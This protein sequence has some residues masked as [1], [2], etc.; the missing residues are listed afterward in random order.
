M[1]T[2]REPRAFV[3]TES[4]RCFDPAI[5]CS[6]AERLR[7]FVTLICLAVLIFLFLMPLFNAPFERDQGTYATIARGWIRGALPYKDLW[8]NKGPLLYL[9]YIA[10]F[11]LFGEN[12]EA[13]RIAA[14]IAAGLSLFFVWAAA[15]NLFGRR[16]AVIA[17]ILFALFFSDVFLQVTA[18]G[19]VFMLLPL[20]ASFWAFVRGTKK[21]GGLWFLLSGILASLAVFTRQSAIWTLAGYGTWL[22]AMYLQGGEQRQQQILALAALLSGAVLGALPFIIYFAVHGALYD[23]WYAMF[24]FN[25]GWVAAQSFLLKLVPPLFVEPGPLIGGLI[26]WIMAAVGVWKL[27][28]RN[29][30]AAWLVI[31]FLA[32]SEAAAQT[33]GKG[34]AHYS[35]QLVPGA[36]IAAAFG[37]RPILECWKKGGRLV[38]TGLVIAG[39]MTMSTLLFAYSRPTPESR[40]IVQYT[41]RDYAED[42]IG[43][44]AIAKAVAARSAPGA[45]VYEWGR[46]SQIYFLADRQPC[47]RWFYDRPYEVDKSMLPQVM[48]D[49]RKK[50]PAVILVTAENPPPP[51]LA[52]LMRE[53]YC[54]AGK[55]NYAKLYTRQPLTLHPVL[56]PLF[57]RVKWTGFSQQLLMN[58]ME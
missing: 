58:R 45:C 2:G 8:D 7:T 5:Y 17:A 47:S 13:P 12:I 14:A 55:V 33:M 43:A 31:S 48:T 49:L 46:S 57:G 54:Y 30:R 41:F 23:L 21:K 6:K 24:G 11:A 10:S 3:G 32:A 20:A 29:D 56:P 37:F 19:E 22:A 36:A 15:K 26:F 44:P 39:S 42:A 52:D 25:G 50:E 18:N 38:R 34:S 40:F 28:R 9:W 1:S 35:I 53:K 27:W 4:L 16:E 51:E